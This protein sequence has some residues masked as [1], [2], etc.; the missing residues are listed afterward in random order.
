V[1][2]VSHRAR[3]SGVI[4][5]TAAILALAIDGGPIAVGAIHAYQRLLAPAA[6]RIGWRC[7]FMPTCSHYAEAVITRDGVVRG[8]WKAL[9]R[10]S[11]CGPWTKVG[12]IDLP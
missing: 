2:S 12:T 6:A 1:F 11:R 7:R 10:V 4:A 3:L 5:G 8:G 9:H